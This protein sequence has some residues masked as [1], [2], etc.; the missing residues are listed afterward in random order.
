MT[1]TQTR[2]TNEP[3]TPQGKVGAFMDE[4]LKLAGPMRKQLNKV[5]PDHWSF[6]MGEIALYSFVILLLTG[7]YLTFFFDPSMT[8]TVYHGRYVPMQGITMSKAYSSTL[9]ISFDVRGGL[10]IRQIHHWSA[11]LF[12]AAML[13]H[14]FRVFF[15]GA[16]RKPRELNWLIGLGLITLGLVEGFAGYSLPDDLLS[17]TGLRIADAIMLSIPVIG[18][19]VSFLVFGGAFPGEVIIG[20]LY[21]AHV[22]LVPALLAGLIGAHLALVVRQK[23]TQFPGHGRTEDTV[24]GERVFP[25][26]AAKAGGF[27]FIVFGVCAALGGLAQINPVWLF[28]PYMPSQVSSGSQPD[29]YIMFLDGSTRLFPAWEIRVFHHTIPALFWPTVVLPG[30]LFTLAGAYPFIEAKMT[31]DR[32]SHHLLQRPRDVPVRT[33]LGTMAITFYVVL[34]LSGGND[35]IAKAFDIS[36][37]AMTWAGRIALLILPPIAYLA[38]Y[39]ICLGLQRHDREVLEHGVETGIIKVLPTGEFI[40]VHQPIG[41]VDEHGHGQ[42]AYSGSPVPKRM[43]Q[44]GAS[45]PLRHI[46][47]FFY[48]VKEKPEIQ[49]ALDELEAKALEPGHDAEAAESRKQLTD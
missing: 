5:F 39:R 8:E 26:Y 45:T 17:G 11:L 3:R 15:T 31:K 23:H 16:F 1:S 47:G 29:W 46:R 14:M 7:T 40:E 10:I 37:N 13:V 32:A 9:D 43:N 18:T 35:I 48:P 27:F 21:I 22:L 6:M 12:M 36:L 42:L 25:V 44:L 30:I 2:R 4:R 19:W 49:A 24:S 34:L 33:S 38:T 28:G 41:P 20:R